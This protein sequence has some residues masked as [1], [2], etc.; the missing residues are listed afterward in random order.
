MLFNKIK[1][2]IFL[3]VLFLSSTGLVSAQQIHEDYQGTFKAEIVEVLG[4]QVEYVGGDNPEVVYQTIK[5]KFLEGP[6]ENQIVEFKSNFEYISEGQKVYVNHLV[7]IG[8]TERFAITN[9]DR[10]DQ[11]YFFIGLFILTVILFGGW[12]GVRSILS[13]IGSF[14]AIAFILLPGLLHGLHPLLISSLVASVILFAA[15]FFTHGFNKESAVA[16]IGTMISV[17]LTSLLAL[18]AVWSTKLTG[19]SGSEVTYLNF[20]TGGTLDFTGLLLG[21]IIIGVLGVLDDIAITQAAIVTELYSSNKNISRMEV[22]KRAMRIGKEHVGALVNTL[23]L[24]YTGS[25]LPL[26]LLFKVYEYDFSTIINLEIF[27][28]EI[29]RAIIGSIGLILTVPIVTLLA[30]V[31]LKGYQSKHDHSHVH[32]H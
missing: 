9:V 28:T 31:Y 21:A 26:L 17:L 1:I 23:V 2:I 13:L 20:N 32:K 16:Y 15:I 8:G 22:Y 14:L 7:N 19:F 29:I 24:A 12:Q 18:Y 11:I 6:K 3:S 25:A 5:V 4:E 10:Q 30:I 27:A